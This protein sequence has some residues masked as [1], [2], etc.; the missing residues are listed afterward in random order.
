MI[1]TLSFNSR[2]PAGLRHVIFFPLSFFL[3]RFVSFSRASWLFTTTS[4]TTTIESSWVLPAGIV[5]STCWLLLG[6]FVV[7]SGGGHFFPFFG[8]GVFQ[9]RSLAELFFCCFRCRTFFITDSFS[10]IV[11]L[12]R[13]IVFVSVSISFQING[14]TEKLCFLAS[15][16]AND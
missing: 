6:L 15:S 11:L 10:V 7:C 5:F 1:S 9:D 2:L 3:P 4:T 13:F 8:R 14:N 12:R 16:T